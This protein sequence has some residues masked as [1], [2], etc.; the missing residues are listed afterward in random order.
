MPNPF[1]HQIWDTNNNLKLIQ[2]NIGFHC[3]IY[4]Y[5]VPCERLFSFCQVF[6]N[7]IIWYGCHFAVWPKDICQTSKWHQFHIATILTTRQNVVVDQGSWVRV[8][9][10]AR[11][12]H[13]VIL[14]FRSLQPELAHAN[15]INHDILRVNTLF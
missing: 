5:I 10:W 15:E 4:S 12:F 13:F 1:G 7:V 8:P 6:R 9:L 3:A 14:G 2:Y 11:I